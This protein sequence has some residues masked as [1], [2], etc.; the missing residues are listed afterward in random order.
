MQNPIAR[1]LIF[2]VA[3]LTAVV[4]GTVGASAA[5]ASTTTTPTLTPLV[6][7][8]NSNT[9]P[10]CPTGA[11]NTPCDGAEGDY[12]TITRVKSGTNGVKT[13]GGEPY[14]AN[15]SGTQATSSGCPSGAS[16]YC[17][18][19]YALFNGSELAAFPS[20]GFTVTADLYLTPTEPGDITTDVSMNNSDGQYGDDNFINFCPVTGGGLAV[21]AGGMESCD[22]ATTARITKA[23][24]YRLVWDFTPDA[25]AIALT[26]NVTSETTGY[27]VW[28]SELDA[29]V[30][31]NGSTTQAT[32]A[33]AGGPGY[34]WIPTEN[35]TNLPLSNFAV[36]LGSHQAG[37]PGPRAATETFSGSAKNVSGKIA[38][39]ASGGFADK[40]SINLNSRSSD[41]S[42]SGGVVDVTHTTP[43]P[44]IRIHPRACNATL[45]EYGSY[46]ITGGTGAYLGLT[47]SGKYAIK[48]VFD[49]P[50]TKRGKCETTAINNPKFHPT[51]GTASF[52]ASGPV[53]IP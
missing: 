34:F 1:R 8:F 9:T 38:L 2:P 46:T 47:G 4:V 17:T 43:L 24:W 52:T 23:G 49:L 7:E 19:P 26:Q 42:L 37:Q 30:Y 48:F 10:F 27:A 18:G 6:Q 33:Q 53:I 39:K 45:T 13:L 51:K 41:I 25:G 35:T 36:Q 50:R 3:A 28:G 15:T 22:G 16:E 20:H 32:V 44:K 40:G 29:P 31:L 14:Y 5:S 12:G 11:G 21:S